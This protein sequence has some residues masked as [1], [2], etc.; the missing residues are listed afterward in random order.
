MRDKSSHQDNK[1]E[2]D[3]SCKQSELTSLLHDRSHIS[4]SKG[5]PSSNTVPSNCNNPYKTKILRNGIDSLYLSYHGALSLEGSL[6]L[7]ELKKLAQSDDPRKVALA[8]HRKGSHIFDVSDKGSNPFAYV[9]RDNWYRISIAKHGNTRT[10][11]AYAQISSELLTSEGVDIA[12]ANL[13]SIVQSLGTTTDSPS[14][15]R[16][17]L[18]VDFITDYPLDVIT[19]SD[20]V[21]KAKE[22]HRHI[23][24]RQFSGWS[25]G[26]RKKMSARLYDKTLEM[27]KNPRP[28]LEQLWKKSGWDGIQP[29]WRLEFELRRDLLREFGVISIE[30]LNEHLAGL[31]QYTSRDWLRLAVPNPK[32]KTQSRWLTTDLW[33]TL[34]S[35][36][37]SGESEL[38]RIPVQKGRPPSDKTLFVNGISAYT[39][40]MAREGIVN[41]SDGAHAFFQAARDYHD[42]REYFTGITFNDYVE[43][44]IALKVKSYNSGVN[45]PIDTQEHPA[46][47]AVADAYRDQS[48]GK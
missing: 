34:Q 8:Q 39:S 20:W 37:W 40:F 45:Q 16:V 18:C 28:Y 36:Q 17:D 11:L 33:Q 46:D 48:D 31:W 29:V 21:T 1:I 13:S 9:L 5:T 27:K 22:M 12:T 24:Q 15:S 19:E 23:V 38:S 44:K 25:I 32:D 14:V 6:K 3:E 10:P 30:S 35:T 26:T 41:P 4:S 43:Q 7:T 47:K 2:T 42:N